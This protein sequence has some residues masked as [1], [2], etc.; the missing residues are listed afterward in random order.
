MLASAMLSCVA[1]RRVRRAWVGVSAG[2]LPWVL[3]ALAECGSHG[4]AVSPKAPGAGDASRLTVAVSPAD[5]SI[6]INAHETYTCTVSGSTN[7][8]CTFKVNEAGG[9][10][11]ATASTSTA[12]Y[13]APAAAGTYHVIATSVADPTASGTATVTVV[14]QVVGDCSNLPAVG[15]WE[16]VTPVDLK[17]GEWCMPFTKGCPP[18]GQTANGLLGTY[19]T[20]AFVLDPKSPGTIYLGTSSLGLWK[21]TNCGSTW[22]HIDTGTNANIIDLGRNWSMVMAPTNSQV[23]YTVS[24]YYKGGVYKSVD[25]GVNWE[26]ILTQ[27]VLN[28]TGATPCAMSPDKQVCG[29]FGGFIEKITM[30]PTSSQHLLVGFHQA[31][32]G[33]TSLPG[34]MFD[35]QGGWGCLAESTDSGATW[36]LTTSAVPWLGFDGPGQTMVDAKTWFYGTNSC[37]GLYRTTTGGV[38][39]DGTSS[40]WTKVYDGCVNGSVY[41]ATNGAYYA[42]GTN[43]H[44]SLDGISWMT[45][46]NSPGASSI[47]GSTPLVDDGTTLFVAGG[48]GYY[49]APLTAAGALTLTR[50]SSTPVTAATSQ[51][52]PAYLDYDAAHH[53]LYTSN[54]LGGFWRY[55]A[56]P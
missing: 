51:A 29:G 52:I 27:N 12:V 2:S 9:G 15:T 7:P 48:S 55:V 16:N 46:A 35:G 22:V 44:W 31:C 4:S 43:I 24:G 54:L 6:L 1:G 33:T 14:N 49:T 42:G 32:A 28:A 45:I 39:S 5:V 10:T 20:N 38:S 34:A 13:T 47:N 40:A 37:N 11:I 23:L 25:G 3:L 17:I 30:D 19:G 18:P 8:G 56:A 26:Q 36:S 53:V 21:S 41:H 50:I